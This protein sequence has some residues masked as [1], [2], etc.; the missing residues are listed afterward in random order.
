MNDILNDNMNSPI[1]DEQ[2]LGLFDAKENGSTFDRALVQLSLETLT[3]NEKEVVRDLWAL[4]DTLA[5]AGRDV[6]P[7]AALK[8][9]MI[10]D[11]TPRAVTGYNRGRSSDRFI[12]LINLISMQ[13]NWKFAAPVAVIMIALVAVIGGGTKTPGTDLALQTNETAMMQVADSAPEN[14]RMMMAANAAEPSG[15]VDDLALA[16][17]GE[18]DQD[19]AFSGEADQDMAFVT[20]DSNSINSY[21]AAYDE[22]TF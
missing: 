7:S 21:A 10:G 17:N 12:H 8:Q 16:L 9:R 15:N 3:P 20:K 14:A 4:H 2:L 22:T 6:V 11:V 19:L 1:T 18:A 13:I 5:E